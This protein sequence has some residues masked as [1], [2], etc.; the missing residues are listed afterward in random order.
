MFFQECEKD[1]FRDEILTTLGSNFD[2][3]IKIKG[4][5]HEGEA[6]AFR[7][8]RFRYTK[9]KALYFISIY[10]LFCWCFLD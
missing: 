9:N 6:I 8:D 4:E 3:R 1:F 10:F 2:G 7:K 5:G